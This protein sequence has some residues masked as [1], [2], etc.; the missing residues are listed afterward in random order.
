MYKRQ[1][2]TKAALQSALLS[3]DKREKNSLID[4]FV[5]EFNVDNMGEVPAKF[6]SLTS[7]EVASKAV[8]VAKL[9]D[10]GDE[11]ARKIIA[12]QAHLLARDIIMCLDRYEDP[13]PMRIALTG[14]VLSNNAMMRSYMEAEVKEKYP[15]AVF[16]VSNGENARGVIFD[17]SKDYRYFTNHNDD[18]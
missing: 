13:K 3:W 11:N 15:D 6:Y 12:D 7:P 16:S 1:A 5:K 18:E 17:K 4:L 8:K 10:S 9:A 14:S 2:I